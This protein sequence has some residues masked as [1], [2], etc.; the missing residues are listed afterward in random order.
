MKIVLFQGV[1]RSCGRIEVDTT[2]EISDRKEAHYQE[3]SG[4]AEYIMASFSSH[5]CR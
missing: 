4:V 2:R 5:R 3:L 1:K